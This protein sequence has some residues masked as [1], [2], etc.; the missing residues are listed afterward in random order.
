MLAA[1]GGEMLLKQQSFLIFH[2]DQ[3]T[4]LQPI[5]IRFLSYFLKLQSHNPNISLAILGRDK[6]TKAI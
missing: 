3:S 2:K 1:L 5:V 6:D 4:A